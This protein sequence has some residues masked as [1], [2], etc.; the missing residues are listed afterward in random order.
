MGLTNPVQKI[1]SLKSIWRNWF[2][3]Q[4]PSRSL[5]QWSLGEKSLIVILAV[6]IAIVS[7]YKLLAV[8]DLKPGDLSTFEARAPKNANVIDSAALIQKKSDLLPSTSVQVIDKKASG[9]IKD[10]IIIQLNDLE[11]LAKTNDSDRIG[12]INLTSQERLWLS[13]QSR[14]RWNVWTKEII[15]VSEKM[16]S[17]GLVKTLALD[18]LKESAFIQLSNFEDSSPAKSIGSKLISNTLQGKSNLKHDPGRSQQLLEELITKQGIPTIEVKKGD[19]ITKKGEAITQKKYDVLDHFG[20]IRRRPRPTEWFWTFSE[21]LVSCFILVMIMRKEKPFLKSKHA[22]LALGLLLTAQLAK[23]WF[24]A[25]ISPLQILVPPTLLLSQGIGPLSALGWMSITSLLWPVPVSGIGEGRL[26]VA[27]ITASLV[28]FQGVQMRNRAQ[29][30]QI[31]VLLPFSALLLEWFL[32]KTQIAPSNS[33]WGKLAPNSE[34]LITEVL[35]L[36]AMLMITILLLPLLENAFGLLTRARLLELADQERPLLRRLSREAPGTFEHTLMICSLAEEGARSI[37]ADVDL[38]K[39]GGLYHDIGKLHA[40]KWFIENQGDEKNPHDELDNPYLSAD[41]LQAHVDEGLKLAKKHNLPSPIAD[42]IPEHQGTLKMGFFLH[43]AR[44]ADS[45]VKEA[46]FRYK[47]PRPRSKETA[48]L[49]LAD[50]CEAS[51][52]SLGPKSNELEA[53]LTIRKIIKSRT[54]DGQLSNSDLSKAEIELIV[55]AFINVWKRMRHRRIKYPISNK[56]PFLVS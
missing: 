9:K 23:D 29:L 13:N 5:R 11:L 56:K 42:F 44:E 4:S 37:G 27:A 14:K 53:T 26:V 52:R 24:G 28:A 55:Y 19:L 1:P 45:Y 40:P 20:L 36:G 16:L 48:I 47:G 15:S 31:A 54:L 49:M 41:I 10:Q 22:L 3:S 8:P 12:P 30:L 43:K 35:V 50:G 38:I 33:A 46:R 39:T 21:A 6:L 2:V 17:Q 32:L 7:S 18:Q 51:L 34:T 25:A